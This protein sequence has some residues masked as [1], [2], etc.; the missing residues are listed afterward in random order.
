ML[1]Y[2]MK[3]GLRHFMNMSSFWHHSRSLPPRHLDI[4]EMLPLPCRPRLMFIGTLASS[5]AFELTLLRGQT[6]FDIL[7][8]NDRQPAHLHNTLTDVCE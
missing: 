3:C 7:V 5:V 6:C 4:S 8:D 2:V 1:S